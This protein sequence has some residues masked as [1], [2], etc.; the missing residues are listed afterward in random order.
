MEITLFELHLDD[1]PVTAHAPFSG[2]GRGS[3]ESADAEEGTTVDV[4]TPDETA[5]EDGGSKMGAVVALLLVVGLAVAARRIM[6][7]GSSEGDG[8]IEAESPEVEASPP[9]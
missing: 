8:G 5:S 2:G 9:E 1:S 7:G 3:E 6:S 4:E